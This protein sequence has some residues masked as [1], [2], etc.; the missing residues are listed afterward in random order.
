MSATT[1]R[2]VRDFWHVPNYQEKT[3][4]SLAELEVFERDGWRC[5]Y[6]S[7]PHCL[8][9]DHIIPRHLG[10]GNGADN[11]VPACKSCNASKRVKSYD[12]F[13]EWIAAELAAFATW[14]EY[15]E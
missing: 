10:G 12:E 5:H 14:A 1:Y 13:Q 8:S 9:T 3:R 15:R 11:L 4:F 2:Q 6:C 7:S